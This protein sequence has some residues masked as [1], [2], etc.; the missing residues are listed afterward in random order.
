MNRAMKTRFALTVFAL[1][2]VGCDGK[3][4]APPVAGKLAGQNVLM[5]TLDTTRSD[6]LG[7]Y[8]YAQAKTPTLDA[9]AARGTLF[10]NAFAQAPLTL[11]SHCSMMTGRYPREH[12]VRDNGRNALGTD[13]PALAA[14]LKEKGYATGAF[15][16]SFVL[17]SRYG[18]DRGFDVYN[19]D[20]GE[21]TFKTQQLAW[22]QPANVVADRALEW[23]PT[24]ADRP[25]FAWVH[26]YDAHHPYAPPAEFRGP[27]M[28]PYDGELAFIDAQVRRLMDWLEASRLTDRT[29]VLV[30]GDHGEAFGEHGENGHSNFLYNVNIKVPM[31]FAHPGVIPV[32]KRQP[33]L[34]EVLD[35]FPTLLQLFGFEPPKTLMSRSIAAA[36]GGSKLPDGAV[37][38]ESNFVYDSFG[39][40]EQRTLITSRWKYI[41]TARPELFDRSAD[42]GEKENLIAKQPKIA[43][44]MLS[45]LRERYET[46][47]KGVAAEAEMDETSKKAMMTFGYMGGSAVT[48]DEFLTEGLA[49]PKDKLDTLTKFRLAMEIIEAAD[50]PDEFTLALP[51][52]KSLAT[53]NANAQLFHF[54]LGSCCLQSNKPE[55]AQPAFEA[56]I[57]L[58]PKNPQGYALMGDTL[59]KL[60]RFED[61]AKHF[62]I[63]LGLDDK[64][65]EAHFRY[66]EVLLRLGQNEEAMKEYHRSIEIL[67][68][69]AAAHARLGAFLKQSGR[70]NEATQHLEKALHGFTE[71]LARRPRD[72]DLRTRLAM[73]YEQQGRN[74]EAVTELREALRIE[75]RHGEALLNLGVQLEAGGEVEEAEELLHRASAA[76]EVAGDAF[77][78]LAI[79]LNK[80]GDVAG[81][82]EMYEK[83]ISVKPVRGRTIEELTGYYLG[84]RRIPDAIRVLKIGNA[85]MPENVTILNTLAKLYAT[86]Q[87]D[88]SRDGKAA[89]VLAT[90]AAQLTGERDPSVLGT[91]AA[92]CA[93]AG[94]FAKAV[95]VARQ[96]V[97]LA[98][99][100][101]SQELVKTIQAQLDGYLKNTPYRDPRF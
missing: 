19:D 63:A 55:L 30:V 68:T 59:L 52:L 50:R 65:A 71:S 47:P 25:F 49:D 62:K 83:A 16:A 101:G 92:S 85:S 64:N 76:R 28:Q 53:E 87:D 24:V 39:W 72:P 51:L 86:A 5:I 2:I 95:Q 81:S 33:A 20:M 88:G 26:F 32:G 21:A 23:L 80:R 13:H 27:D 4:D 18:L 54:M 58:D 66:A 38:S 69:F 43:A 35:V 93:E 44:K 78:G 46:M 91:L 61:A 37:Y 22:Q 40:A 96:A 10:E 36:F 90:K 12:G 75:P 79:I 70:F 3:P 17:D 34:V 14:I 97:E 73:V 9:L 56:A 15:V 42:P 84:H 31:I 57:R 89:V 6:R 99:K 8:G 7:C 67:P 60:G 77:H 45:D 74:A 1:C 48:V 82:L 98:E 41:S 94:D 100:A 29:V 11:P